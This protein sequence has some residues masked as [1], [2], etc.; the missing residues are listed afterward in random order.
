MKL[1]TIKENPWILLIRNWNV[2]TNTQNILL[3]LPGERYVLPGNFFL[4]KEK[5]WVKY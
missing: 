1:G 2:S 3:S 4:I 5:K